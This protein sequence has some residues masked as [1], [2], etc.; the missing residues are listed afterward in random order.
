MVRDQ[1]LP[2]MAASAVRSVKGLSFLR[3][4]L[5]GLAPSYSTTMSTTVNRTAAF[6]RNVPG[7]RTRQVASRVK[8]VEVPGPTVARGRASNDRGS[9]AGLSNKAALK[10][11]WTLKKGERRADF[12]GYCYWLGPPLILTTSRL[13]CRPPPRAYAHG[14]ARASAPRRPAPGASE[15]RSAHNNLST[16]HRPA[17]PFRRA[18]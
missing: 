16:C 8:G 5:R 6:R 11:L 15:T 1:L 18:P 4:I 17:R 7:P 9:R 2:T 12:S 10:I 13:F 3:F 14:L